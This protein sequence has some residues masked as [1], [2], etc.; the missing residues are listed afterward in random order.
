LWDICGK[1]KIG[2]NYF[3]L[4]SFVA[5]FGSGSEIRDLGLVKIRIQDPGSWINIRNTGLK[6]VKEIF[7]VTKGF[8]WVV[9]PRS[10]L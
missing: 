1:E 10:P 9:F 6:A 2:T 8:Y 4:F 5:V 3:S 7:A